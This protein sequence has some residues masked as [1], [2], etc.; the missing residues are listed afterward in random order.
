MYRT[1]LLRLVRRAFSISLL[2]YMSEVF[3]VTLIKLCYTKALAWSSLV[4][5]PKAKSS[6]SEIMNPTPFTISYH[7]GSC[8]AS[9]GEDKNIK[10]ST[11]SAFPVYTFSASC[12]NEWH[13]LCEASDE[14]CS[15]VSQCFVMTE[16]S[17]R[18]GNLVG[19]L[20]RPA[21]AK[22]QPTSL[23]GEQPEIGKACRMNF[24]FSVTFSWSLWPLC[25][26]V[27]N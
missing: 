17:P 27:G 5:V 9:S 7:L 22:R 13:A 20:C 23:R 18:K 3:S 14:P 26:C 10:G 8:P 15:A 2:M 6:S 21:N 12:V 1:P 25:S 24:P 11:F 19:G 16:G 4:P